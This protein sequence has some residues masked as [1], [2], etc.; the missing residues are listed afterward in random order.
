MKTHT[1]FFR[2]G[3]GEAWF[4][5]FVIFLIC[6]TLFGA[7]VGFFFNLFSPHTADTV[8][9]QSR[10]MPSW[11]FLLT[12][13]ISF[14]PA[15][16]YVTLRERGKAREAL[17]T[18]AQPYPNPPAQWGR[19]SPAAALLLLIV[20]I[21][22]LGMLLEPLTS[23][24]EMPDSLRKLFEK[25]SESDL[26]TFLAVVVAAP[27]CE[28]WMLRGVAL[29]GMLQHSKKPWGPILWTALMFAVIHMNPWQAIPAF[30][31]GLVLGWIYYRTRALWL[32]M[33]GHAI[34]NGLAFALTAMMPDLDI[35]TGWADILPASRYYVA[36]GLALVLCVGIAT[37]AHRRLA[38]APSLDLPQTPQD[39]Q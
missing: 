35:E 37:L 20:F 33:V 22:A 8:I 9:G 10:E 21:P 1:Q 12:Y 23:W 13:L 39:L 26:Y 30:G 18:Q 11:L 25:M 29:K 6:G 4:L 5:M 27:I 34:N 36:L 7:F 38:P 15:L 32:C 31:I 3:L 28:E 17:V 16:L 19:L 14:V 2:P 24:M